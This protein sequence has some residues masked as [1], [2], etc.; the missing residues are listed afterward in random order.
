MSHQILN[1]FFFVYPFKLPFIIQH[2]TFVV[3]PRIIIRKKKGFYLFFLLQLTFYSASTLFQRQQACIQHASD[4]KMALNKVTSKLYTLRFGHDRSPVVPLSASAQNQGV[5]FELGNTSFKFY[6]FNS[7]FI[8]TVA[9]K[10]AFSKDKLQY[11]K[12]GSVQLA[13]QLVN[14]V[15]EINIHTNIINYHAYIS[16]KTPAE[17]TE[18]NGRY[19]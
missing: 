5:G 10:I 1:Q 12:I 4:L 6:F 7:S 19:I 11:C 9:K 17:Y 13:L 14:L 18:W 2:S 16:Q 3:K 15:I 8:K